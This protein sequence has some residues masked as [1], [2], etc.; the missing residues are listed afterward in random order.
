MQSFS[1]FVAGGICAIAGLAAGC[2]G[3]WGKEISCLTYGV[4]QAEEPITIDADWNKPA[5]RDVEPLELAHAMGERPEHFP[6]VQAKVAYDAAN[7]YVIFRVKDRYV[8]AV[9]RK[10]ND[11]VCR[12]SCVEL[13]FTPGTDASKGYFNVETNCGGTMLLHFQVIPRRDPQS[14][15]DDAMN[16][17]EIAHTMPKIVDREIA[18][19]TTWVVEYRLPLDLLEVHL[20]DAVRP[21][22]GVVWRANFYKCADDTSH[23]HW[24]TWAKVDRPKPDFHVPECFGYLKF[25]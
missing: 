24:L 13:F 5:W 25:H 4:P 19:P 1:V 10:H 15:S 17:I 12:D 11:P 16:R 6:K 3:T 9:A 18:E 2:S 8:R 14:L 20:P 22:P 23:P 7:L 21:A